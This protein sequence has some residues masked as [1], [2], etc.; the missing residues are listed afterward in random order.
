MFYRKKE[1]NFI[2]FKSD[3]DKFWFGP[4]EKE[5]TH[6][7]QVQDI[8]IQND[9]NIVK[10]LKNIKSYRHIVWLWQEKIFIFEYDSK[11]WL[12]LFI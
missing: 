2:Y 1:N 8:L 4:F 9:E 5:I 11:N 10:Q 12:N 3:K 7:D 6:I